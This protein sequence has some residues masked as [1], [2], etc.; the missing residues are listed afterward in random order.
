MTL[1]NVHI[2]TPG[3]FNQVNAV[4][5]NARNHVY[6]DVDPEGLLFRQNALDSEYNLS[7]T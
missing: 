2:P 6:R 5:I 4:K 7:F 3:P 1:E